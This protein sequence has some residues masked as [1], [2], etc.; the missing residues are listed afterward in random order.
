MLDKADY[1]AAL[2]HA[3]SIAFAQGYESFGLD[4]PMLNLTAI[5]Y[6]MERGY[7]MS[8]FFCFYMCDQQRIHVDKTIITGPMIMI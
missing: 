1:P 5:K 4:V 6:L 3:E 8:P 2:A 7:Q